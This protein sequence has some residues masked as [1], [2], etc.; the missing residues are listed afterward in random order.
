MFT[1]F[2]HAA[3]KASNS[4]DFVISPVPILFGSRGPSTVRWFIISILI[5]KTINAFSGRTFSH[6]CQKLFKRISP[7]FA[8]FYTSSPIVGV[9]V[10][11]RIFATLYHPTPN[12]VSWS[13]PAAGMSMFHTGFRDSFCSK[14]STRF[15]STR[16]E[17]IVKDNN[18]F[19]TIADASTSGVCASRRSDFWRRVVDYQKISKCSS[20]KA[21]SLRYFFRHCIGSFFALFSSER[22]AITDCSLRL[23]CKQQHAD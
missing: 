1:N 17:R 13:G 12:L 19:A 11:S 9:S 20:C 10:V 18:P 14:A 4:Q 22:S 7:L 8:N 16:N 2:D 5:W 23:L 6:I 3:S 15:S 21:Y